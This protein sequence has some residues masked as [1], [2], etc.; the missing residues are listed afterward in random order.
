MIKTL[1]AKLFLSLLLVS[2][3]PLLIVSIVLYIKTN[4]GYDTVLKNEQAV[5]VE[6][7]SDRLNTSSTELLELTKYYANQPDVIEVFKQGD[8]EKMA[9][10]IKST[11]E[12]L[13]REH[14]LDVFEGWRYKWLCVF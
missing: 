13:Q 9:V 12:R 11:F 4:Q 14:Q 3:V 6:S 2:I 10:L 7:I 5:N 8:R 1:K